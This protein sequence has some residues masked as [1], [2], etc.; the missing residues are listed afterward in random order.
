V[1]PFRIVSAENNS[2]H[3]SAEFNDNGAG[4]G[5]FGIDVIL[6]SY[7]FSDIADRNFIILKYRIINNSADIIS[8]LYPGLFFDW[9]LIGGP[10]DLTS[11]DPE[12]K[13]GFVH[14]SVNPGI[15][16][17][18]AAVLSGTGY[19]FWGINNAGDGGFSIYDGFSDTEKFQSLASGI[20]KSQAG[21][22]DISFVVSTGPINIGPSDTVNAGFAIAG[23]FKNF[24]IECKN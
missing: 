6:D 9:D 18:A 15:P 20:G 23:G 13:L 11:Y 16:W 22:G 4:S 3:G 14:N 5:K 8:N 12:G 7:T 21:P 17:I 2:V 1:Q 24:N 10:D 19:G